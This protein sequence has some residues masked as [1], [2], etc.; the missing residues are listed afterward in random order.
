MRYR[1]LVYLTGFTVFSGDIKKKKE[2]SSE[3]STALKITSPP[4]ILGAFCL[5][6]R[7][8]TL[9]LIFPGKSTN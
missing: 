1:L 9:N 5:F 2:K 3:K 8:P 7:P 6:F 4:V